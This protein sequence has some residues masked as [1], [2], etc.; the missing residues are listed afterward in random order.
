MEAQLDKASE[1]FPPHPILV[2][3]YE[4]VPMDHNTV[5]LR[6]WDR[7]VVLRGQAAQLALR[8]IQAM[9]GEKDASQLAA[10]LDLDYEVVV[11]L[12]SHLHRSSL[13]AN[14]QDILTAIDKG[15]GMAA[16]LENPASK[17]VPP[18]G[19][20][21]ITQQPWDQEVLVVGRDDLAQSVRDQLLQNG[22]GDALIQE[23]ET[24]EIDRLERE[25]PAFLIH[26]ER[27]A[28]YQAATRVNQVALRLALP[29]VAGWLEGPNVIVT[30][31]MVPGENA[32]FE[33]LLLRQRGHYTSFEIDMAYER[34]LRDGRPDALLQAQESTP[35][36]DG[37]LAGFLA[38][39]AI[40]H[41]A[42][43]HPGPPAPKLI[44]FSTLRLQSRHHPVLRLP[45]CPVCG[46]A[47]LQQ[48][49]RPFVRKANPLVSEAS[50]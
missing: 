34:Y 14:G 35:G 18:E 10:S 7:S 32:C 13:L 8:L 46:P 48:R 40:G 43:W 38:M 26:A 19:Q 3:G 27:M 50:K 6:R 42:G 2:P 4:I 23:P 36:M 22:V 24:I 41:M 31:V 16:M 15:F 9:D 49:V 12:L 45:N 37:I 29:W 21:Q 17:Y 44:E 28:D 39:R 30:H 11:Q 25:R 5:G 33:C 47:N 1:R 20:E